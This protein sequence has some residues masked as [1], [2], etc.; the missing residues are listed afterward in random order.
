M[1]KF[2]N[3]FSI[4][5]DAVIFFV[6]DDFSFK[7][8][9]GLFQ[10]DNE[11]KIRLFLKKLKT[12]KQNGKIFSYD[13]NEKLKCFIIKISKK[14]SSCEIEELGANLYLTLKDRKEIRNLDFFPDSLNIEKNKL[15]DHTLSFIHG[16]NL[17]S[18]SFDKYN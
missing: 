12:I 14:I 7:S 2:T 18:Y 15:I 10:E 8:K 16:F 11:K 4:S 3:K 13:I 5:R 17:K 1:L 6:N 9:K